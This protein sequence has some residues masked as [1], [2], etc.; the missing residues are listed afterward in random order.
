MRNAG[1]TERDNS[2]WQLWRRDRRRNNEWTMDIVVPAVQM[3]DL[4]TTADRYSFGEVDQLYDLDAGDT[5]CLDI[6][7][8]DRHMPR[9]GSGQL[10][11]IVSHR[12]PRASRSG[13]PEVAPPNKPLLSQ[14]AH[15]LQRYTYANRGPARKCRTFIR[16]SDENKIVVECQFVDVA[17]DGTRTVS[18]H[19]VMVADLVSPQANLGLVPIPGSPVPHDIANAQLQAQA[20]LQAGVPFDGLNVLAEVAE[21]LMDLS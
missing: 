18:D 12:K 21:D 4:V 2:D 19:H 6:Y 10:P 17:A 7:H 8:V 16:F 13:A 9:L 11:F 20:A 14:Y 3:D 15:R 1:I 5:L